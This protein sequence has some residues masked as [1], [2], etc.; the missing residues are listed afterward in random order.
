MAVK[1]RVS[2]TVRVAAIYS[3]GLAG[4]WLVGWALGYPNDPE[5]VYRGVFLFVVNLPGSIVVV[6][7]VETIVDAMRWDCDFDLRYMAFLQFASYG[8]NLVGL[9]IV[10][11]RMRSRRRK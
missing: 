7:I 8:V 3:A 10:V 4:C 6:P 2:G 11:A 5:E 9:W 1:A